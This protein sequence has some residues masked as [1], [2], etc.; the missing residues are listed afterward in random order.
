VKESPES[1]PVKPKSPA[2]AVVSPEKPQKKKIRVPED[3][4]SDALS[5]SDMSILIDST[6]PR[7]KQKNPLKAKPAN[8]N[9]P[10]AKPKVAKENKT[11][12]ASVEDKLKSLKTL[13]FKCGVRKQWSS[14]RSLIGTNNRQ[15]EFSSEMTTS[16]QIAH[17]KGILR[18]L[19]MTG[20]LSVEKAKQIKEARE[21]K[22]ELEFI[23][24]TAAK[25][26][27]EGRRR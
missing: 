23:Q 10:P 25:I 3:E 5:D 20:R 21:L 6:P 8:P 14:A 13:V 16:Q 4:A 12:T 18:S 24:E 22:T 15:K 26:G 17:V 9:V 27:V 19:G 7:K 11:K 2:K 1:S